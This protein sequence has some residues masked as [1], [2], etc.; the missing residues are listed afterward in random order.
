MVVTVSGCAPAVS[1]NA[2]QNVRARNVSDEM[3][4]MDESFYGLLK[5]KNRCAPE[6]GLV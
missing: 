1:R 5:R 3:I 6:T 2:A 4:F